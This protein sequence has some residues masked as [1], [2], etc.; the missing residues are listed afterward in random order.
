MTHRACHH[1]F[2]EFTLD[3][4]ERQL[5]RA[6]RPV[7]L[8]PKAFDLLLALVEHHGHLL[9]KRQLLDLVWPDTCVEEGIIAVHVSHLRKTLGDSDRHQF[10]ETMSASGY[11]F[12]ADV[13]THQSAQGA[14]AR[15]LSVAIL[16]CRPRAPDACERDRDI[17]LALADMLIDRLGRFGHLVVRPTR[18]IFTPGEPERDPVRIGQLLSVDVVMDSSFSVTDDRL[19]VSVQLASAL[20]GTCLWQAAFEEPTATFMAVPEAIAAQVMVHLEAARSGPPAEAGRSLETL[21]P[22]ARVTLPPGVHQLVG[23]G[24]A[25]LSSAS[26]AELP[27]AVAAFQAAIEIDPT[28]AVAHAG[29]AQTCCAQAFMRLRPLAEAYH[30]AKT[31]ALRALAMDDQSADAQA[32]LG[33]V[34]YLSEW[35][36]VGAEKSLTRAL[37]LNP[38]HT[39]AHLHYGSLLEARGA[40]D[41]GLDMKW[42]A[43]E[44]DPLCPAVHLGIATSYFLRRQYDEMIE[45]ANRTLALAPDHLGAREYIAGAFQMKGDLDRYMIEHMRY[46]EVL[47]VPSESLEPMRRA[48]ASGGR[49]GLLRYVVAQQSARQDDTADLAL[50]VNYGELED[51]ELAFHHL[52]RAVNSR[53]PGL[54]HLAVSPLWDG[55]RHDARFEHYLGRLGLHTASSRAAR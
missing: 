20:D 39:Q 16:P 49:L 40:L 13:T 17:G 33:Q 6:T 55:L 50:A 25:A 26:R 8:E 47:G 54:V 19:Q 41:R 27:N 18:A 32:A 3:V 43:L 14:R 38:S 23:R 30:V 22:A 4:A 31:A 28:Y 10:I 9:T 36:W 12:V 52:E 1:F 34:L 53:D 2:G 35:D 51:M 42:K 5:R 24:R 15:S 46:A 7:R 48:Y 11:R 29:L 37:T 21:G 44:R 45:W